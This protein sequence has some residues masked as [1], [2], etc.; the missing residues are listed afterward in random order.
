MI[1]QSS[2]DRGDLHKSARV[3]WG[4]LRGLIICPSNKDLTSATKCPQPAKEGALGGREAG[5]R[6]AGRPQGGAGC[7][8]GHCKIPA[9]HFTPPVRP[10]MAPLCPTHRVY[11]DSNTF[12]NL[13]PPALSP[14]RP[15]ICFQPRATLPHIL[16]QLHLDCPDLGGC[17]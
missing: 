11:L 9:Q 10:Y 7:S 15:H 2:W 1:R 6:L 12:C 13:T 5:R 17:E 14:A 8:S 3:Y 16:S 4:L